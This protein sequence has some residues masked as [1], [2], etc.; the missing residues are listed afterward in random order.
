MSLPFNNYSRQLPGPASCLIST[1]TATSTN[2]RQT[3]Q[4]LWVW[5]CRLCLRT[6]SCTR[7]T[8][9]GLL[10]WKRQGKPFGTRSSDMRGASDR[11]Q[12]SGGHS[13]RTLL[14][15]IV[16]KSRFAFVL[17]S[18]VKDLVTL[19]S[20]QKLLILNKQIWAALYIMLCNSVF[21]D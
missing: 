10:T 4:V 3:L 2:R 17:L 21:S 18:R 1:P 8:P 9:V 16:W 7:S 14:V 12:V 15:E 20:L 13:A 6:T 11:C 5:M 19:G